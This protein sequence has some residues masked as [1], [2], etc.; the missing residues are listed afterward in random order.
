LIKRP[1]READHSSQPI[2]KANNGG[3]IPPLPNMYSWRGATGTTLLLQILF[4]K[5]V[6]IEDK[7]MGGSCITDDKHEKCI[8]NFDRKISGKRPLGKPK[9]I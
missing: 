1:E 4:I 2:A 3:A 8:Q 7:G 6:K 5:V 9:G